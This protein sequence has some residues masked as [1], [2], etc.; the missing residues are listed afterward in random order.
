VTVATFTDQTEPEYSRSY[1]DQLMI[2]NHNND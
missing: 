2:K 1:H